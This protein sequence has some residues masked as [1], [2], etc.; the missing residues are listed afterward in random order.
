MHLEDEEEEE[1]ED[2]NTRKKKEQ[3]SMFA[4]AN[5]NLRT[6]ILK[7]HGPYLLSST[8]KSKACEC[9]YIE[10]CYMHEAST[11]CSNM[12]LGGAINCNIEKKNKKKKLQSTTYWTSM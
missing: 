10:V 8:R 12:C 6:Q 4:G 2:R 5:P 9:K 7:K 1:E 11:L 3:E